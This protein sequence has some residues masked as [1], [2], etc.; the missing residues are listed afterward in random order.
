MIKFRVDF[1]LTGDKKEV[2]WYKELDDFPRVLSY[3][4]KKW[5][6]VMYDR[7]LKGN[8]DYILTFGEM[9]T[10]SQN[11]WA[12]AVDFDDIYVSKSRPWECQC[13]ANNTSFPWDHMRYCSKWKPWEYL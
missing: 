8:V 3:N 7:D 10:Y 11:Y 12:R 13:G 9:P 1:G 5:E 6:W 2:D 4:N